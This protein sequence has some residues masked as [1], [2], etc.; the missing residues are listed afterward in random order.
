MIQNRL[1]GGLLRKDDFG[2]DLPRKNTPWIETKQRIAQFCFK[3]L[4]IL[5]E[6]WLG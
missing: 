2:L 6:Q 4:G 3:C 1:P 5:S